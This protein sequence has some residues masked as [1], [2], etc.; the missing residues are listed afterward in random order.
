MTKVDIIEAQSILAQL[1][2]AIESG[3][4]N[5]ITITRNSKPAA[6]LLPIT[7]SA[8]GLRIGVA[9]GRFLTPEPDLELDDEASASFG[10][11]RP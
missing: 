5:E 9:K 11:P 1:V 6:R 10:V 8:T 3:A 7:G 2:N 4:E